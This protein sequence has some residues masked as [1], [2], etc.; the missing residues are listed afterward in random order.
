MSMNANQF[1][2]SGSLL[3]EAKWE[4]HSGNVL[5]MLDHVVSIEWPNGDSA[6]VRCSGDVRYEVANDGLAELQAAL[7]TYRGG[8]TDGP[9]SI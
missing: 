6:V 4:G 5:L 8:S 9:N 2:I 1:D 7:G 3:I